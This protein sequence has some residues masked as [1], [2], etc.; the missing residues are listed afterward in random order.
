MSIPLVYSIAI[1]LFCAF[2]TLAGGYFF[3][4]TRG[5]N[6]ARN[7]ELAYLRREL[8]NAQYENTVMEMIVQH[9]N[10]GLLI[11]DINGNIEWS[12]PAYSRMTG[13]S[14][15]ELQG[16]KPQEF[17]LPP[18]N[19]LSAQE[20][21]AFRYDITSGVLNSLEII[22]NVRKSGEYFWNQLSFAV[23]K[24]D[25]G[26]EPKV[27]VIARDVT[28]QM[29]REED[30]KRAKEDIQQR[31]EHDLLT[32][33]PNR[34]KLTSFLSD[35]LPKADEVYGEI[36]VLHIDLD[37]FKEV[38]DTLGHAA[39]D[40][41]LVHAANIMTRLAE[42]NDLV[43]RFGGD[44]FIIACP[45]TI[46]FS[47]LE[48]LAAKIISELKKPM[49]WGD[50]KISIGSSIGIA[51]S[52]PQYRNQ[53]ELIK[54][55]DMA[56]YEVK[57]NGRSSYATFSESFGRVVLRRK[58]LSSALSRAIANNELGVVLQPQFDLTTRTV[59]GFEALMR[60]QHPQRG[61][62]APS[63]FFDVAEKNGQMED[64][65][66]M[67]IQG[68]LGALRTLR[69]A[70][71]NH[72]RISINVSARMLNQT[73][74]VDKLKWE[75]DQNNFE[76]EDV[77]IEVLETILIEGRNNTAARTIHALSGA[78]FKVELDD[79]G[80][81]YS[82]LANLTQL[83]INGIKIDRALVQ[84]LPNDPTT[85]TVLRTVVQLCHDLG[86]SVVSEG[87]EYIEQAEYLKSIGSSIVQGFGIARP[88]SP[89]KA[90]LWLQNTDMKAI[91]TEKSAANARSRNVA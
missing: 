40:A 65:D 14:A 6:R 19:R 13:F 51:I 44:E 32:G 16:H 38:N 24:Y 20:L 72:L 57:N 66:L 18:E 90:L 60:W 83:K 21:A 4:R 10:D 75:V 62:L 73:G 7:D 41:V 56:L 80:T 9:A 81:G 63:D 67:A 78:G 77:T 55:A 69:D 64:I 47:D 17:V 70:G 84:D 22:K 43:C 52:S 5:P 88:M 85:Q 27:I 36:G 50:L 25:T 87:V 68:A 74:Y 28:V 42:D 58:E 39:G 34:M 61:L 54:Q 53:D 89:Q 26:R 79:F 49:M 86:L 91:L 82:G 11:Q 46:G 45:N 31:A 8:N 12:N 33:L 48:C 2:A 29:E 30:L 37:Q 23:V 15:E 76:P 35:V 3:V 71:F 59:T 1:L